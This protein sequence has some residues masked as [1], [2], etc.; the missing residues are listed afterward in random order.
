M[1]KVMDMY[2]DTDMDKD[3]EKD[4]DIGYTWIFEYSDVGYWISIK[5]FVLIADIMSDFTIYSRISAV[6]ISD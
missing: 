6:L 1:E 3:T 5:K 2:T 4:M